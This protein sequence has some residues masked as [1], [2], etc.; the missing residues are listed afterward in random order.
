MHHHVSSGYMPF[1]SMLTENESAPGKDN[2]MYCTKDYYAWGTV[3]L[4]PFARSML[5]LLSWSMRSVRAIQVVFIRDCAMA[6]SYLHSLALQCTTTI[7]L[8]TSPRG[9]RPRT[10]VTFWR[11]SVVAFSATSWK[12]CNRS[13]SISGPCLPHPNLT[14][15]VGETHH[16]HY[17]TKPLMRLAGS[18]CFLWKW[19]T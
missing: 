4:Q 12:T 6:L 5:W 1:D 18:H 14:L 13:N 15:H 17:D 8:S 3:P 2:P 19:W 9:K 11:C 7:S 16:L 10:A